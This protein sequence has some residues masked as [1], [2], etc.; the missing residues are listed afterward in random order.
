M[1]HVHIANEVVAY[2]NAARTFVYVPDIYKCSSR[3]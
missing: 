3:I 1:Q 2:T